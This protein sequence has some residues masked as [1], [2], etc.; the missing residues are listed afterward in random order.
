[1]WPLPLCRGTEQ[2][3]R[4]TGHLGQDG[5]GVAGPGPGWR[6]SLSFTHLGPA[7][8]GRQVWLRAGREVG[9]TRW[10]EAQSLPS[11]HHPRALATVPSRLDVQKADI[12]T[13]AGVCGL[14]HTDR[15]VLDIASGIPQ[16]IEKIIRTAE[17]CLSV[18]LF[19]QFSELK[20][21]DFYPASGMTAEYS[22]IHT[23]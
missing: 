12:L 18:Y 17:F 6:A 11:A 15:P 21:Q 7:T 20:L 22:H 14:H 9:R 8:G 23:I 16:L 1:M 5:V 13:S 10:A 2:G 19:A 4:L 3:R